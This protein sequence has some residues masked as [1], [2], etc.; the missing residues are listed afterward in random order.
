MAEPYM[1]MAE[2]EAKFP[3]E[4]VLIANPTARGQSPAPT[5]GVVVAH[6]SDR[7]EFL[8]RFAEWD[9]PQCKHIATWYTGTIPPE[10]IVPVESEPGAA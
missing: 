5:G 4:W 9:D 7:G 1:T 2:I 8:R 3:N 6:S 10:E